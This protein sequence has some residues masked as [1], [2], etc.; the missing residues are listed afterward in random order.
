M[1]EP[2]FLETTN[3]NEELF[4]DRCHAGK[5]LGS[6]LKSLQPERDVPLLVAIGRGGVPVACEVAKIIDLQTI[7][8][9]ACRKIPC[10]ANRHVAM[11]VA[12]AEDVVVMD[13][14]MVRILDLPPAVLEEKKRR[15]M[16]EARFDQ[17]AF[18]AVCST[19]ASE[20]AGKDVILIDD[21]ISTGMTA[22][23][24]IWSM[25]R[26]GARQVTLA[27]PVVSQDV[28]ER[29]EKE[30]DQIVYSFTM[31]HILSIE[32]YYNDFPRVT[33]AEATKLMVALNPS[34]G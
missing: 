16:S 31:K 3:L 33:L 2:S 32:D 28:L 26:R 1:S 15:A 29:L 22:L 9:L 34:G 10:N 7:S 11:G 8:A 19:P 5:Y 6:K 20:F 17:T 23:A 4:T 25:Q 21:G 14:Q 27:A 12:T 13:D 30:C 18:D 24:A